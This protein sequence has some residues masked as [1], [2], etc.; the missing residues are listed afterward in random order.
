MLATASIALCQHDVPCGHDTMKRGLVA[1]N[2]NST[3]LPYDASQVLS[4]PSQS[5]AIVPSQGARQVTPAKH[6]VS[7]MRASILRRSANRLMDNIYAPLATA[8][9]FVVE[10]L[11]SPLRE[12]RAADFYVITLCRLLC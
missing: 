2:D 9:Q 10:R 12:T 3:P 8:G 5:P 1:P 7:L 6:R 4:A 11:T